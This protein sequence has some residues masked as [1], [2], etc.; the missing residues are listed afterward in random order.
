M[1][2]GSRRG[3]SLRDVIASLRH[4]VHPHRGAWRDGMRS[5]LRRSRKIEFTR[6]Q[7]KYS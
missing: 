1:A 5:A 4:P 2:I 6:L 7:P 3:D